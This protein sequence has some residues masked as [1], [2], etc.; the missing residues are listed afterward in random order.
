MASKNEADGIAHRPHLSRAVPLARYAPGYHTKLTPGPGLNVTNV[1]LPQLPCQFQLLVRT[2]PS[3][4]TFSTTATCPYQ[5]ASW[6][7]GCKTRIEGTCGMVE[8]A[9]PDILAP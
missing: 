8:T 1:S 3:G 2:E 5:P 9:Q 6:T 7:P 4:L